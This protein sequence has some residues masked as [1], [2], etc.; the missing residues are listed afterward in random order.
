M[1]GTSYNGVAFA[2]LLAELSTARFWFC[3]LPRALGDRL[4]LWLIARCG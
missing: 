1:R 4:V 2:V 3:R